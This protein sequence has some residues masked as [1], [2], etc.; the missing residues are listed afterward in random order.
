MSNIKEIQQIKTLIAEGKKKGFLTYE[1]LSKALP[2]DYN[3]PEQLEEIH[4][5]F[6]QM[7]IAIVDSEDMAKKVTE[8][9]DNSELELEDND[10]DSTEY[11]SRSTDP[12]RMYLREMGAVPLLDREGEVVIAKKIENGEMD[13]LYSLVEVPVAVE[14]LICVGEDL[15]EGR[16]KLKDVVKTIEEDDPSEDEMNQR[17][18]VIFLL[19]E[20]R[21]LYNKKK[22][23]YEKLDY[24]AC[25]DKRVY[26]VQMDILNFKEEIVTRLRDIKLEKTLI[27]RIIETVNDYVRQ[28]H[29]CQR[30]LSAYVLSVGQTKAEIKELFKQVDDREINPVVA[31]DKL[32]MTVEEFFSFKEML[33]GKLEIMGRLQDKCCHSVHD[34]EE[35]L[36]RIKSG[37]RTAMQAKQEL[38]RANLR[39]VVSI[40]K[41][42]TNRGLQFLDLIQEGNIGLMKAVDKFEYQR[43]YKFSTYATWWIRQAITRAIADQARTIRIPVHMIETINKLIRT[44][45]YLVQELGRD[46]SPE[47]IAERMDYPLEKV[48]KVLKIAKE[49]ISLE[50]PIGD[51]EDSSLGDF[52]ED[53][54]A[55]APAEEVV[56][57][58]LGEQIAS[59]LSD[60]TPREEQVLRKRFGI[61]EKSDHTLEEV[62]KLF[63]VTRERI[64]QIEAKALRKLRH[65][66][67]SALLRSYFEN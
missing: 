37:T 44:S 55:T 57:T 19:A 47:E 5:I 39:L 25:L 56:S 60:L 29:N 6:D 45:R 53:K 8:D 42:Y 10:E 9:D 64:R 7:D 61:G 14:E 3:T 20:V 4:A 16:I 59:V 41:K 43:G 21:K 51:E 52:I 13:V 12:V 49:P 18:R 15:E 33:A 22:K 63:N 36:W 26:S 23:I 11:A 40:A 58:K 32:G 38:I 48:K 1:E 50:T 62:G 30:D 66:V 67:R 54:K 46:P 28:M 27:D 2:S 65:P 35:V 34:L 17:Q 31:A 24:C